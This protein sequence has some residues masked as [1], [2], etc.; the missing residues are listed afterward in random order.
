MHPSAGDL[1]GAKIGPG[2]DGRLAPS[3]GNISVYAST[4]VAHRQLYKSPQ[5]FAAGAAC[6]VDVKKGLHIF[7]KY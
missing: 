7:Q 3:D 2:L 1:G 5:P 4:P 6:A